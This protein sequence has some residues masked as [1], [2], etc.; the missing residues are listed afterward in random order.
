MT[1]LEKSVKR[2]RIGTG[3][4]GKTPPLA[5]ANAQIDLAAGFTTG[6]DMDSRGGY[7][8]VDIRDEINS[9]RVQGPR[10]VSK[11]ISLPITRNGD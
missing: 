8:T 11:P 4:F 5:L 9:G 7:H 3:V 2:Y 6:L 10:M 1:S